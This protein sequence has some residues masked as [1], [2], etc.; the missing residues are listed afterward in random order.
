MIVGLIGPPKSGK[1]TFAK[2]LESQL[3]FVPIDMRLFHLQQP[4][5]GQSQLEESKTETVKIT[6]K[7]IKAIIAHL[8]VEDWNKSYV[9]Y[10]VP[11]CAEIETLVKA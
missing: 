8:L 2:Y 7:S 4:S 9:L 3:N 6:L 5:I 1:N 10:P 11:E